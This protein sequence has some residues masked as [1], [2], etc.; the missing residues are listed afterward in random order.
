MDR[1]KLGD[2]D[3]RPRIGAYA[4]KTKFC[5][6]DDVYLSEPGG[7]ALR[8]P[9]LIASVGAG[10]IYTLSLQDGTRVDNGKVFIEANLEFA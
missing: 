7:R 8:G 9:Y 1:E 3:R 10:G 2:W 4:N 6:G 5:V